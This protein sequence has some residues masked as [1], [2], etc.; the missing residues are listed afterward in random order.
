MADGY[1]L[2]HRCLMEKPIWFQ[3]TPE[4]KAILITLMMLANHKE[5]EWI[6]KGVKFKAL[7]GQF[8]TSLET[9]SKY[10]GVS[11]QNVRTALMKFEKLEFLTNESTKTGRLITLVN[12]LTYQVNKKTTNKDANKD[13]T[14]DQQRPNKELTP[15]KN[16]KNVKNDKKVYK[17][18][19]ALSDDEFKKLTIK[20]DNDAVWW[21]I[22]ELNNYKASSG[23]SY[24]SDYHT[25]LGWVKDKYLKENKQNKQT[26]IDQLKRM[27]RGESDEQTGDGEAIDIDGYSTS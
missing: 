18:L 1:V 3:S 16:D 5:K 24:K 6:W 12:W 22:E 2:L 15:T 27:A 25:I 9:I 19:V 26:G 10:A 23:K 14:D 20:Y 13:L 17:E 7:P 4:Q 11:I 21:M 8:V